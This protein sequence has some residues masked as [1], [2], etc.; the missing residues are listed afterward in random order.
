MAASRDHPDSEYKDGK[1]RE[2]G[3]YLSP[4]GRKNILY[5]V[6]GLPAELLKV[7]ATPV[8]LMEEASSKPSHCGGSQITNQPLLGSYQSA[9]TAFGIGAGRSAKTPG[10]TANE[11]TS[12]V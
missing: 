11:G 6:P 3:K 5:F 7:V 4:P 12:R 1:P 2:R 10:Q 9:W 8:I